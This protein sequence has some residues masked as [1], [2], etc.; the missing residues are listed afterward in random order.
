[1]CHIDD[2]STDWFWNSKFQEKWNSRILKIWISGNLDFQISG[3]RENTELMKSQKF[4]VATIFMFSHLWSVKYSLFHNLIFFSKAY[5]VSRN[6]KIYFYIWQPCMFFH[7][8]DHLCI[9]DLAEI[10]GFFLI[11]VNDLSTCLCTHN[12][13]AYDILLSDRTNI[14]HLPAMFV[15]S[16]LRPIMC[17]LFNTYIYFCKCFQSVKWWL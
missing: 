1:M 9:P 3:N 13:N 11:Y 4:Y 17:Y 16:H 8:Y 2:A 15:L 12:A 14:L 7:I 5:E 6:N 10:F